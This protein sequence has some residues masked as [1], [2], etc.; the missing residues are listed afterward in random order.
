M[1]RASD[2]EP[3][4]A[5]AR[6]LHAAGHLAEAERAYRRL[7]IPL[8]HRESVLRALAELYLQAGR[9][10]DAI[11]TLVALTD[12]V[13]DRLR[14][15]ALLAGVLD[16]LGR[17]D[18][19]IGHYRRL[20]E[21]QPAL[22]DAHFNLALLC[23][24]E[25]HYD[26][27]IAAYEDAA[28]LGIDRIEEV[29]SNLGVLYSELRQPGQAAAMYERALEMDPEYVP[30]LFNRAGLFEEAG[31][32]E[33][34]VRMYQRIL[35]LDPGHAGALS[36]LAHANRMTDKSDP[37]LARLR[38]AIGNADAAPREE[39]LFALGKALDDL[40]QYD[41]AFAAYE[42]AN[43]LGSRRGTTY[44]RVAAEEAFDNLIKSFNAEWTEAAATAST[45]APVFICGMFRSGSTLLE[46]ILA[47]HPSV[48]AGGELDLL[49]WLLGRRLSA[50]PHGTEGSFPEQIRRVGHEYLSRLRA[51]FPGAA[52]VT[53]KRPDNFLHLGLI[54]AMFPRARIVYT[55]RDPMDN[56]LSIYFQYLGPQLRYAT[57]LPNTAHYYRQHER[58]MRHW[59]GCFGENIHTVDYDE[60]VRSPESVL[61]AL[62]DFL[63]L[64]W[65]DRCL[66]F[67]E[68]DALVKTASVWQVRDD[69]HRRSSGRWRNYEAH[70]G[71]LRDLL[72]KRAS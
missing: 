26:E 61:R 1:N 46:Q 30:A 41:E 39:L 6:E 3:A 40:G 29:W 13:P 2:F 71:D 42:S 11:A 45:A 18:E 36:R 70:L 67:Q 8:A 31:Q 35:A 23:K 66:T 56:C 5:R 57:D 14:Y 37:L 7:D 19:A 27:A 68:A 63:K 60:L 17:T 69:L 49:P 21:R 52:V 50:H 47:A 65:D 59:N 33:E 22:G 12:V 24:K 43:E 10:R 38:S 64:E 55:K 72:R 25:K 54:K 58:L 48:T 53:D 4:F 51:M 34:A 15:Y 44:D 20:L 16:D 62:L 32:R 9:H 28:R